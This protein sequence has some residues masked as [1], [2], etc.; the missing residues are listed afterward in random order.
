MFK[1]EQQWKE[2]ARNA[3]KVQEKISDKIGNYEDICQEY[4]TVGREDKKTMLQDVYKT[5]NE[6]TSLNIKCM[7]IKKEGR[8]I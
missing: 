6:I 3:A 5:E 7:D 4:C 2:I 8:N 1:K